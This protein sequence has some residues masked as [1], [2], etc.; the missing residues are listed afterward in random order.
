MKLRNSASKLCHYFE[1]EENVEVLFV[2]CHVHIRPCIEM[3]QWCA[4]DVAQLP[5]GNKVLICSIC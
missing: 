3:A 4:V 2:Q 1:L 5:G